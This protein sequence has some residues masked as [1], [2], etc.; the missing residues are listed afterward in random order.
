MEPL[1]P[2]PTVE[3][4]AGDILQYLEELQ[5]KLDLVRCGE[6]EICE[7]EFLTLVDHY[8]PAC[9]CENPKFEESL[10]PQSSWSYTCEEHKNLKEGMKLHPEQKWCPSCGQLLALL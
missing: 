1:K 8:C 4:L 6:C 5:A 10:V 9:G 3:E 7:F 2:N